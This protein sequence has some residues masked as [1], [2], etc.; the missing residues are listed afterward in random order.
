MV[1]NVP[2][3]ISQTLLAKLQSG[4]LAGLPV[5][6]MTLSTISNTPTSGLQ[7][8]TGGWAGI[9]KKTSANITGQANYV[10]QSVGKPNQALNA[11]T[12]G[13][14]NADDN[15]Y[16]NPGGSTADVTNYVFNRQKQQNSYLWGAIPKTLADGSSNPDYD[17]MTAMEQK[18]TGDMQ[19]VS[20]DMRAMLALILNNLHTSFGDF[21][22]MLLQM[23]D[24]NSGGGLSGKTVK[25]ATGKHGGVAGGSGTGAATIGGGTSTNNGGGKGGGGGTGGGGGWGHGSKNSGGGGVG[26]IQRTVTSDIT[27]AKTNDA[28][29]AGADPVKEKGNKGKDTTHRT[30]RQG[31]NLGGVGSVI[32]GGGDSD[33]HSMDS[34][35]LGLKMQ[36]AMSAITNMVSAASNINKAWSDA[37]QTMNANMR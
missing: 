5:S 22:K 28:T 34:T 25:T 16:N 27:S 15:D 20:P 29:S 33:N 8:L 14:G 12:I 11:N 6:D 24:L 36:F 1:S 2:G 37:K 26:D 7:Q 32:S 13:H 3:S 35:A 19:F 31:G 9:N 21:G 23:S 18:Y 17:K 4:N 10:A 30:S